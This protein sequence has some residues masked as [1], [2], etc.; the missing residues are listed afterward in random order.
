MV[1][2]FPPLVWPVRPLLA[3]TLWLSYPGAGFQAPALSTSVA[4]FHMVGASLYL[5]LHARSSRHPV[6]SLPDWAG[7]AAAV[8]RIDFVLLF[9]HFCTIPAALEKFS[10]MRKDVSWR[11]RG[12]LSHSHEFCLTIQSLSHRLYTAYPRIKSHLLY[13][14]DY[15]PVCLSVSD[16]R[17]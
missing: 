10:I 5:H 11:I 1:S 15:T 17:V 8:F 13:L 7:V 6:R 12:F 2:L 4:G 9:S 3:A 14:V 16:H